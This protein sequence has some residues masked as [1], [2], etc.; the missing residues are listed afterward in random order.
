MAT[1]NDGRER[2]R[3]VLIAGL[4]SLA[5]AVTYQNASAQDDEVATSDEVVC[6]K[7]IEN[8]ADSISRYCTAQNLNSLQYLTFRGAHGTVSNKTLEQQLLGSLKERGI[9]LLEVDSTRLKGRIA[10]QQ[11]GTTSVVLM[12]CSLS[13]ISGTELQTFRVREV[14]GS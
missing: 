14:L 4:S 12:Q 5:V 13:D 11:Q 9:T 3:G 10:S 1:T 7:M 2:F 8:M 6:R